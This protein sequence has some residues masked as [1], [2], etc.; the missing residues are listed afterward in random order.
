MYRYELTEEGRGITSLEELMKLTCHNDD[1]VRFRNDFKHLWESLDPKLKNSIGKVALR[2]FVY[3]QLKNS[4]KLEKQMKDYDQVNKYDTPRKYARIR[5]L[6][7]LWRQISEWE[8]RERRKKNANAVSQ[9]ILAGAEG[10]YN[11]GTDHKSTMPAAAG[12]V[13][14]GKGKGRGKGKGKGRG[15]KGR[16]RG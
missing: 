2:D 10:F 7:W 8:E 13:F 11:P 1:I 15:G 6:P 3:K 12:Y 14:G 9:G 4:K 5:Q 16:G